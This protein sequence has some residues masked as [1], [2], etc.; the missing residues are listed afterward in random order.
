MRSR[1]QAFQRARQER[2]Y[3]TRYERAIF[4]LVYFFI[5]MKWFML[6]EETKP[7]SYAIV[8]TA[9]DDRIPFIEAFVVPYYIWFIYVIATLIFLFFQ[10]GAEDFYRALFFMVIGMTFFLVFSTLIPTYQPLRPE[11]MPRDNIFTRTILRLYATDTPTN[12]FPSIHVYNSLACMIALNKTKALD[13]HRVIRIIS[14][15]LSVSIVLSTMFIKQHSVIDVAG[16]FILAFFVYRLIYSSD[17]I[18]NLLRIREREFS[19]GSS[20]HSYN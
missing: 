5:Y 18:V 9:L 12:V 1:W 17:F 4:P 16:A 14:S 7:A 13:G 11:V 2:G 3:I 15:L 19:Q 20:N 10:R 6:L 8:H